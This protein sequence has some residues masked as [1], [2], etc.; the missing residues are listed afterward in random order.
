RSIFRAVERLGWLNRVERFPEAIYV[1]YHATFQEYF[2]ALAVDNWDYFLPRNHVDCPVEGKRYRIFEPQWKQVIL[3]WLGREDVGSEEKEGFIRGLVEFEDG[4]AEWNF[5]EVDRGLYEYRADFLAAAGI[6]EFKACSLAVEIVLNVVKLGFGYF[7]IQKQKWTTFRDPIKEGASK[8]IPETIRRLAI[9]AMIN[10]LDCPDTYTRMWAAES[11]GE[12]RQGNP[13]AITALIRKITNEFIIHLDFGLEKICVEILQKNPQAISALS[14][15]VQT[16]EDESLCCNVAYI[17]GQIDPRNSLSINKLSSLINS[18]DDELFQRQAAE[19][20]LKIDTGNYTAINALLNMLVYGDNYY[21][22][23]SAK[24]L[25]ADSLGRMSNGNFFAIDTLA[26]LIL[27]TSNEETGGE[28]AYSLVADNAE[29]NSAAINALLYMIKHTTNPFNYWEA[30]RSLERIGKGN[31]RAINELIKLLKNPTGLIKVLDSDLCYCLEEI[32]QGNA[33]AISGLL[34]LLRTTENEKAR[35]QAAKSLGKIDPG[36]PEAIAALLKVIATTD[37]EG[38]RRE[39][40]E[41]LGKIDPGNP[42]AIAALLKVIATTDYEDTRREAVESL[43]KIDPG[44]PEAIAALLKVIA[45][46]ESE[47]KRMQAA[48]SLGK[49]DPGNPE[50]IAVLLKVIAT[51]ESEGNRRGAASSL[52]KILTTR[53]QYAEVVTTLKDYLSNEVYQNNF[54]QFNKYYEVIWKC[55]ANLPYPEFYQAWH[56]LPTTL[57]PKWKTTPP[58]PPPPSPNSATSP[59][60]PKSSTKPTN[61][62]PSTAKS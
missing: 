61:P 36:N 57:I 20:L 42:E 28:A 56:N 33:E 21:G 4:C 2:A 17:L 10:L 53:Q 59:F 52:G 55:A 60:S 38:T 44:N 12:V 19:K 18:T 11:L 29:G 25:A 37:Y 5:E 3:L 51:T 27:N 45:T 41:S 46:T 43:G 62:T 22:G 48:E 47:G 50:A 7:D 40:V 9:S 15:I 13:E 30:T 49:I 32:G 35:V 16:T 39:A 6:N 1:F 14:E 24:K 26:N 34:E 58:Q 54:E 23:V 8:V 31:K